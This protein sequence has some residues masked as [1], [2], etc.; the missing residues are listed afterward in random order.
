MLLEDMFYVLSGF[1]TSRIYLEG[2]S[3]HVVTIDYPAALV[4]PFEFLIVKVREFYNVERFNA[5]VSSYLKKICALKKSIGTIEELL[6]SLQE[7]MEVFSDLDKLHR[8]EPVDRSGAVHQHFHRE[9]CFRLTESINSWINLAKPGDIVDVR[10][11]EGFSSCF[12]KDCF[13]IRDI[14]MS[15]DEMEGIEDCGKI[16]FFIRAIFGLEVVDDEAYSGARLDQKPL[17]RRPPPKSPYKKADVCSTLDAQG[18]SPFGPD[19]QPCNAESI[20]IPDRTGQIEAHSTI[21]QPFY[22][23]GSIRTRRNELHA[24]LNSLI[25]D[26]I[27]SE[28]SQIHSIVYMQDFNVFLGIFEELGQD[29]LTSNPIS[30][31]INNCFHERCSG[32]TSLISLELCDV[33]LGEYV[34]KLLKYHRIPQSNHYLLNLQRVNVQFEEGMLKHFVPSRSFVELKIIFRFL[35]SLG[36]IIYYLERSRGY[37]FTRV[38]YLIFMRLRSASIGLVEYSDSIDTFIANFTKQSSDLLNSFYLTNAD[39]FVHLSGLMEIGY[40]YLQVE[41]KGHIDVESFNS[42][43]REHVERLLVEVLRYYGDNDFTDFLKSLNVDGCLK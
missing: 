3:P 20:D 24:I 17:K 35:F 7:D 5:F 43:T 18:D 22:Y 28:T 1:D 31:R 11:V 15:R 21:L 13:K 37:N 39:I 40:E 36:G 27:R 14:N 34:L 16:V 8:G 6:V 33:E 42:R 29:L 4:E 32:E 23:A 26:K 38:V 12:W 9:S 10:P 2:E 19:D 30:K 41:H 25:A